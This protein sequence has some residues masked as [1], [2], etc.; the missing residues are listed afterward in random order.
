MAFFD[1]EVGQS[2]RDK[3][4]EALA[5]IMLRW[6]DPNTHEERKPGHPFFHTFASSLRYVETDGFEKPSGNKDPLALAAVG[7]SGSSPV[8][9]LFINPGNFMN[10]NIRQASGLVVHEILHIVF[11]HLH[12]D[13]QRTHPKI[14]NIATDCTINQMV[15][16]MGYSL[17]AGKGLLN[18]DMEHEVKCIT[19]Q[20]LGEVFKTNPPQA[21]QNALFYFDWIMDQL[22]KAE[23]K[24]KPCPDCGGKGTKPSQQKQP[25][26]N[27]PQHGQDPGD[28]GQDGQD[29][30]DGDQ[31]Q[32]QNGQ[33]GQSGQSGQ[34]GKGKGQPG[35]DHEHGGDQPC[36]CKNHQGQKGQG[37][38]QGEGEGDEDGQGQGG[39]SGGIEPCDCCQGT[40]EQ[41]GQAG[42]TLG[43]MLDELNGWT[44]HSTWEELTPEE[45]DIIRRFEA[46]AAQA[47]KAH[48]EG[49]SGLPGDVAGA[50]ANK[51]KALE[52]EIDLNARSIKT[53]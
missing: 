1:D 2:A 42:G 17:P 23:K 33:D 50:I 51:V 39:G 22:Q 46:Q 19:P 44:N 35:D 12:F 41:G 40:G 8:G 5:H 38:G 30:D 26:P 15:E 34:K 32:G 11:D 53:V 20:V 6:K 14:W 52:P 13:Q 18:E 29:G 45:K 47:A 4:S 28:K 16:T 25:D 3:F 37:Q 10:L 7:F 31:G 27:C 36:T 48:H 43:D 49:C 21:D 9:K 24:K